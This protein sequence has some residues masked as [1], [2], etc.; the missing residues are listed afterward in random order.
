MSRARGVPVSV[1]AA[2]FVTVLVGFTSSAAIV[3]QAA[4]AGGASPAEVSSWIGALGIGMGV[5]CIGLSLR[6]RAPIVTAWSTPGAALLVTSLVG[7]PLADAIGAFM[8][9]A[10]LIVAVGVSGLFERAIGHIPLPLAQALLAGVLIRFG[11]AVFTA[12]R[13]EFGLV[14]SMFV[15][16]VLARRWSPRYAMVLVLGVGIAAAGAG[17]LLRLGALH[18]AVTHPHFISPAFSASTM[19]SV[20]I[21]LFLVTMASQNMP[22]VAVLRGL[23]YQ[24][25]ISP[26]ITTTGLVTLVLAPFG[27]FAIN[28]AAITAAIC[29]GP[30]AHEDPARRYMASVV[31]GGCYLLIG[32]FGAT[33]AALFAAFPAAL[34]A[35]VAG[36][37][38]LPTIASSL[39]GALTDVSTREPALITFL[40]TASGVTLAGVGSAFWGVVAGGLALLVFTAGACAPGSSGQS[41]P[42]GAGPRRGRSGGSGADRR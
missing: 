28:L 39:A 37:A 18:L 6:Y 42:T 11:L 2:G 3:F 4:R 8:F 21:P 40:V 22:G 31:A 9:S 25:P 14:F 33:V 19:L 35:G 24:T 1:V 30:E 29:A 12:M 16:Y 5:T 26:L 17:G 32:V 41:A 23:G 38:L 34:V 7:V 13:V 15:V 27:A 10:V 36:L 20:G